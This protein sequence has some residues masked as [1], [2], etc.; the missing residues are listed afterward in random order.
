MC[1]NNLLYICGDC[2]S[3]NTHNDIM[4]SILALV[5][6]QGSSI[7]THLAILVPFNPSLLLVKYACALD[8]DHGVQKSWQVITWRR[9]TSLE[10]MWTAL[11]GF[12]RGFLLLLWHLAYP[13]HFFLYFQL[14]LSSHRLEWLISLFVDTMTGIARRSQLALYLW[15]SVNCKFPSHRLHHY[16]RGWRPL[17]SSHSGR[18]L[19]FRGNNRPP[20]EPLVFPSHGWSH[21]ATSFSSLY[22]TSYILSLYPICFN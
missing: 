18:L 17:A 20:R 21:E 6:P 22:F 5:W 2:R 14:I 13:F 15:P 8:T 19:P 11:V 12:I 1:G 4:G 7:T 9:T 16:V 3:S 10:G